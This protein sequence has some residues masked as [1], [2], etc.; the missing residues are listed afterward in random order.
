MCST[1]FCWSQNIQ[2]NRMCLCLILSHTEQLSAAWKFQFR[3][4]LQPLL[5]KKHS[6]L[7]KVIRWR[8]RVSTVP[9]HFWNHWHHFEFH[10]HF[11]LLPPTILFSLCFSDADSVF[12]RALHPEKLWPSPGPQTTCRQREACWSH[13]AFETNASFTSPRY[14]P[15]VHLCYQMN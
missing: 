7:D 13:R 15:P 2:M 3:L 9:A 10:F 4:N 6:L 12:H 14:G 11:H 5:S 8:K 1:F